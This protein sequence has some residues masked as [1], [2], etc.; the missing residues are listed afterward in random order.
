MKNQTICAKVNPRLLSKAGRL[1]TGTVEGRIIEILQNA[2]RAGATEVCINNLENGLV[3]VNDDGCG[4]EDF[5]KLLDLGGS[6]WDQECEVSEDPAGVG[7][8]SLAPRE[9]S[10]V[11]GSTKITIDKDGWTGKPVELENIGDY[12]G[13]T[14]LRFPDEKWD[15]Q[16]LEPYAVFTGMKVLVDGSECAKQEFCSNGISYPDLGCNIEVVSKDNLSKWHQRFVHYSYVPEVLV[17][18]HGQI[19]VF[20][21]S[22][23]SDPNLRFLVDMTGDPTGIRLMLPA[24]T[25]LIENEALEQLKSAIEIE[26]YRFLQRRGDHKL[27]YKEFVRAK[28]LGIELP[29]SQPVFKVGTLG[30]DIVEPASVQKPEDLPLDKCY[31]VTGKFEDNECLSANIHLLAAQGTFNTPFVPVRISSEY[32]G[33][34]WANLPRVQSVDVDFGKELE[35]NYLGP[36]SVAAVESIHIKVCTSNGQIYESEVSM[37]LNENE[38]ADSSWCD[39]EVYLTPASRQKLSSSEVWFH[40][41]GFSDEGDTYDTQLY[42]FEEELGKFWANILGPA[43]Y[44]GSKLIQCMWGIDLEWQKVSFDIEGNVSITLKDGSQ[45][46]FKSR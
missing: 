13:G 10:V 41:G 12:A 23:V 42:C 26:A 44:L 35:R 28:A 8:F 33:Y 2:R 39:L 16:K 40:C 46:S 43:E 32:Q 30:G 9:L 29:E 34:S 14:T 24:R 11:S 45:K 25:R 36:S 22:P 31:L 3:L 5:S 15:I 7:I 19:V 17:N 27:P 18:F 20:E 1:F 37:A 6:G 4:I 21:Y 38:Q